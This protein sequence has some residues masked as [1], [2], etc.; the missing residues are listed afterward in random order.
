MV[1]DGAARI[2]WV[3][4]VF[5]E[6]TGLDAAEM[7]GATPR[8][9]RSGFHDE[10]FYRMMRESLADTGGWQGEL[11]NRCRNGT[12]LPVWAN[13]HVV[14][15]TCGGVRYYV[16]R[17]VDFEGRRGLPGTLH[18]MAYFDTVT[19][20]PNRNLFD[21][22]LQQALIRAAR[23]TMSLAVLFL[24]LNGFKAINDTFG[25]DAGDSLLRAVAERLVRCMREGD[26]LARFGGDE[27]AAVLPDMA[28]RGVAVRVAERITHAL[29]AP[30]LLDG[31]EMSVTA[32]IGI[33]LFPD[34]GAD[35]A[36]LV[37]HADTA[38]YRAK[39]DCGA[40]YRFFG[41]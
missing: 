36:L 9:L 4:S 22:R 23:A 18:R 1:C 12:V 26:T 2:V 13:L 27:F 24:D 40:G 34:D 25:H 29:V 14:Y 6:M 19:G 3:N 35:A 5:M 8:V 33:S 17:Y 38:M 31:G 21:D 16:A 20:L 30:F 32:S 41:A 37:R 28:E 7:I 15:D 10:A 11:W 39:E